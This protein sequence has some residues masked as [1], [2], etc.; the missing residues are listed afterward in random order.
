MALK[1]STTEAYLKMMRTAYE[2][3][4]NPTMPLKHFKLLIKCQRENG[5]VLIEGKDNNK[6]A[7]EYVHVLSEIVREKCAAVIASKHFMSLLSD[8][9]QAR[10]TGSEKELVMVRVERNSIPCY[11]MAS[12]LEMSNY[13]GGRCG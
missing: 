12:L 1:T 6:A 13:G 5:V 11:L 2:L 3:A 8:G 10:K 7:K 9:S 4:L